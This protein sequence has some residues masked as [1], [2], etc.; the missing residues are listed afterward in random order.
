MYF[1]KTR[2][3]IATQHNVEGLEIQDKV[4]EQWQEIKPE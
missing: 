2:N 4:G 3:E 1:M